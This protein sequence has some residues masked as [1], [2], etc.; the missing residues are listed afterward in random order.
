M[1]APAAI[2]NVHVKVFFC[3]IYQKPFTQLTSLVN[4]TFNMA[5]IN[6]PISRRYDR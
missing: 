1:Y 3:Q 2:R 6:C 5:V 4:I